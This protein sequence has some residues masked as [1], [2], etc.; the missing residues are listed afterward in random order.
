MNRFVIKGGHKLDGEVSISGA[1][2]ACLPIMTATLLAPGEH[3]I[4]NVP[5]LGDV[6]TMMKIL[7]TT[8]ARAKFDNHTLVIDTSSI[9]NPKAPYA[10]VSTMRASFL[11]TGALLGRL[12]EAHV[13]RP[14]GCAIGPRPIEEHLHGFRAL[15][16]KI[17]EEHGY[18]DVLAESL[19]GAEIHFDKRSV[20]G[21]ENVI[22][23][24]VLAKGRT[25]IMNA[26]RE[27]HVV[28]LIK[29]LNA[30][31]AKISLHENAIII[32]GVDSLQPREYSI[33]PDYNE[34]G[35]FMIAAAITESKL[36]LRHARWQDSLPEITKLRE[37]GIE[38]N[39]DSAG[40]MVRSKHPLKCCT[41]ETAPY[42][43]FPTEL[44]PQLTALLTMAEGTSV[45]TETMYE[46]RF[47]HI[48]ELQRMGAKVELRERSAIIEGVPK[49]SGAKVMASDIRCGA[50]LVLAGLAAE[51]I[52]EVQRVYHI[53]RGYEKFEE[54]LNN[55]G[56][57]IER[58]SV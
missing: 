44:Q 32:D 51:G 43:G 57:K 3:I 49:L 9:D 42:P 18:I 35:T 7:E 10:L 48:P 15:G 56:A 8:G 34:V 20:T 50:A 47:N 11:I 1:K 40:I 17:K 37:A 36:F 27:P 38:I 12:G 5:A 24:A 14:G 25:Q 22:L 26:A 55:L 13:A 21:T 46:Q 28:D 33:S 6:K 16:V 41:V 53:D 58:K 45:I 30:M 52:T 29:F 19:K 31:G 39:E 54:K 23:A 4:H 2:N